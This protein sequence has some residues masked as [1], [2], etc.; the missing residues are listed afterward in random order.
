M[1]K[2]SV[3]VVAVLGM[4]LAGYAEAAKPKKRTRNQNRVG[5]YG[6]A[7]IGNSSFTGDQANNEAVALDLFENT[8]APTQGGEVSTEDSDIAYQLAFGYRFNRYFAAELA[9]A[10]FGELSNNV[11]GETNQGTGFLPATLKASFAA[12][13][14]IFSAVGIL[15]INDKFELYARAGVLF[16]SS[17]REL[18]ARIQGDAVAFGRGKGDSTEVVLAGGL[19]WH[20][21]QVYSVRL[22]HQRLEAGEE[23]RTGVE[24]IALTAVGL[25]VRF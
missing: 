4:L 11:R 24:D 1:K 14:P 19:A 13:G 9:L 22:E 18:V 15:P 17:E 3:V 23:D 6:A 20:F 25:T 16:A 12:G 8:L 7:L 21:N 10:Q 5:P 2:V